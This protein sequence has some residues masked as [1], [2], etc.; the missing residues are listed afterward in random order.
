ME[1]K[2]YIEIYKKS[3]D[4]WITLIGF[5]FDQQKDYKPLIHNYG[6][7]KHG[8]TDDNT[9]AYLFN[10]SMHG[11]D[12]KKCSQDYLFLEKVEFV[13][14]V[15]DAKVKNFNGNFIEALEYVIYNLA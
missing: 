13:C 14:F 10:N 12:L 15:D 4:W 6:F 9:I 11:I 1:R 8:L 2:F 5:D 7:G 3:Q